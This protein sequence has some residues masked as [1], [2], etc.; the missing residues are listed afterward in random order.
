MNK[1]PKAG[2]RVQRRKEQ[3]RSRILKAALGLFAK[4]GLE[5]TT[6]AEITK[7][8]DIGKGTFFTYFASKEAVLADLGKHLLEQ[9]AAHAAQ[10]SAAPRTAEQRLL[11]FFEPACAWHQANPRLSKLLAVVFVQSVT[12][13][14]VEQLNF[15]ALEDALAELVREGQR[16]GQFD[17]TIDAGQAGMLLVGM[18]FS[19]LRRWHFRGVDDSLSQL[20]TRSLE[21]FLRGLRTRAPAESPSSSH[22]VSP[23]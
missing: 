7:A 5:A 6:I 12:W 11:T 19:A 18:Y 1:A 17:P 14:Q 13:A 10:S 21:L 16:A 2:G 4:E 20:V 9:M 3:T 15:D 22:P 23:K 8:A